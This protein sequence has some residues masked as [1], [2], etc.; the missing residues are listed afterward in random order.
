MDSDFGEG[1]SP[2]RERIAQAAAEE[3]ASRGLRFSIRDVAARLGISTKTLYQNFESKERIIE[4]LVDKAIGEMKEA[5]ERLAA[6]PSLTVKQK[7]RQ[8][9]VVL[10]RGF[11]YQTMTVLNELRTRYPECWAKADAHLNEGWDRIRLLAE[12]G[13]ASEEFRPFDIELF[14]QAYVGAW[15]RL[16]EDRQAAGRAPSMKKALEGL[17][18]LLTEGVYA[19]R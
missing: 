18:D 13:M 2:V 6:D 15:Y 11:A 1:A 9:L 4:E 16:M 19:S 3:I 7:F 8:A 14:I 12:E 10:P 17:A 5:E